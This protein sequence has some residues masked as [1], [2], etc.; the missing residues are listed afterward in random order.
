M[1]VR[2]DRRGAGRA[3]APN[4]AAWQR[5]R[6]FTRPFLTAFGDSDPITRG[7]DLLLQVA[8]PGAEG[9]PHATLAKTGHFSQEDAGEE[10]AA[11]VAD[12]VA[13]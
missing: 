1:A 4:R 13:R 12:F 9:Q 3:S 10:L 6:A 7:S 8:I 11:I 5:L 2:R